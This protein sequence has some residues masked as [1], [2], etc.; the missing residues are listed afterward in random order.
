[1]RYV[2]QS[3]E[4]DYGPESGSSTQMAVKGLVTY[5]G[6]D[7][8]ASCESR[9]NYTIQ[10]WHDLIYNELKVNRPVLYGGQSSGGG[11]SFV[12][13]GYDGNGLYH[14][15]W[16]WGGY[17]DGYFSLEVLN[18]SG[19]GTGASTTA[20]GYSF[21]QN[22][23]IGLI[24]DTGGASTPKY[25]DASML[26]Y[27]DGKLSCTFTNNNHTAT[28]FYIGFAFVNDEGEI[29][30]EDVFV[31]DSCRYPGMSYSIAPSIVLSEAF[32]EWQANSTYKIIPVSRQ[33]GQTEWKPCMT[34]DDY[35]EVK[36][37][38][39]GNLTVTV[40]PIVNLEVTGIVL[41]D[42]VESG[43]VC[44]VKVTVK[45]NNT[46]ADYRGKLL[47][48]ATGQN[49][50][51]AV[52]EIEGLYVEANSFAT[53]IMSPKFSVADTY[54]ITFAIAEDASDSYTLLPP[55][56]TVTVAQ[57]TLEV[58]FSPT[59]ED[60]NLVFANT[61]Y[62]GSS[63]AYLGYISFDCYRRDT[64]GEEMEY[65]AYWG[66]WS[67]TIPSGY[68]YNFSLTLDG[69][70]EG[71]EYQ[72]VAKLSSDGDSYDELDRSDI[73][74]IPIT[75]SVTDAGYATY[76][77]TTRSLDF[78]EATDI[79]AYK[80]TVSGSRVVLTKVDV[81]N[82]GDGVILC[83]DGAASEAIPLLTDG[84]TDNTENLMV[85]LMANTT[86]Y[87]TAVV[88]SET[89]TNYVLAKKNGKIAFYK[90]NPEGT[91]T[92]LTAGKAYLRVP[93]ASAANFFSIG[94]DDDGTTG[95]NETIGA[96]A[97]DN[98]FYTLQGIRVDAPTKGLYI[99]RGH[100]VIIK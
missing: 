5:M 58:E 19:G 76:C 16:G 89:Y 1:M 99:H 57:G 64:D 81:V 6:Y 28:D 70:Q 93:A 30:E 74:A 7:Q 50:E 18:P 97:A 11:H 65:C 69:I 73:V 98:A 43:K 87:E 85:G 12:V 26:A 8:N 59:I 49:T 46:S 48:T 86:I 88:G 94:S 21:V 91:G 68:A 3:M 71:Y 92:A 53:V 10:A 62:N 32:N 17:C 96:P 63:D 100:K 35:V 44:N 84:T 55:T 4:M 51:T 39:S 33:T 66:P 80:A 67:V 15:N 38:A 72:C 25:I 2:G 42:N 37:D 56:A 45:N 9:A 61:F 40:Y 13:D 29:S 36:V 41:P 54:D 24:P 20:G 27:A 82:K 31:A 83:S 52:Q 78:S 34:P 22:C 75:V 90:A 77:P 23:A 14:I 47:L 79:Q 95:I 60:G